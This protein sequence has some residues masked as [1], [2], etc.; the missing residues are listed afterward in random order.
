ML[1]SVLC[2]DDND[3]H[4]ELLKI[5]FEQ[6]GYAFS[7]CQTSEE[8]LAMANGMSFPVIILDNILR[9][10]DGAEKFNKIQAAYPHSKLLFF[11]A[12][13]QVSS[14]EKAIKLGASAYLVKPGD[15]ERV[16]STVTSILKVQSPY[17]VGL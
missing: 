16:V 14:R 17:T 15:L 1:K 8:C 4:T 10:A 12:D 7:S 2:V 6:E 3:D 9:F 13:A 11:T 5:F